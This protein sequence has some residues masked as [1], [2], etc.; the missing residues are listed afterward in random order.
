MPAYSFKERFVWPIKK[1]TK[2]QTIRAKRKHQI[3]VGDPVYLY[4]GMR[5]KWCIKI[6]EGVC[7]KVQDVIFMATGFFVDGKLLDGEKNCH[8][9]ALADG[10]VNFDDMFLWWQE[11][12]GLP[13]KGEIIHWK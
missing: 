7:T 3:K 10:F 2:K 4:Y 13:F 1:G 12:N 9:F 11:N 5:T 8:A 6:G